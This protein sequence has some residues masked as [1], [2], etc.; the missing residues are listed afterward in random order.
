MTEWGFPYYLGKLREWNGRA[1]R[2]Q[3]RPTL[4]KDTKST[5]RFLVLVCVVFLSLAY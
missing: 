5:K 1:L 2:M 4:T 3:R